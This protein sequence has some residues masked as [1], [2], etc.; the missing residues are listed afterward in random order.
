M[1]TISYCI[2]ACNEHEE[3]SKL[4]HILKQKINPEDEIVIQVDSINVTNEVLNIAEQTVSSASNVKLVKFPLNKDFAY[5][6]NNANTYCTKDFIFQIDADEFPDDV[7]LENIHTIIESN[8]QV[9][10]F[11]VPRK[12]T[13]KGL[14]QE[15]IQKW[16]WQVNENGLVNWPDYQTRLYKRNRDIRWQRKVHEYISGYKRMSYL[17]DIE[18]MNLC[19][20]H[21]KTI[22]RQE[23]QNKFYETI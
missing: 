5:F 7:L 10:L 3:L 1:V 2:T 18:D 16:R 8:D 21:P 15:H 11:V 17:P 4:L 9:D 6:K 20:H 13:V 22:E 19:L 14:T 12:N 23:K